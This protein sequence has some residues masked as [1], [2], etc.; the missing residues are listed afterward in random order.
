M[1]SRLGKG[2]SGALAYETCR[3]SRGLCRHAAATA[4]ATASM[5]RA[6]LLLTRHAARGHHHHH[7][8]RHRPLAVAQ[9]VRSDAASP[10]WLAARAGVTWCWAWRGVWSSGGPATATRSCTPRATTVSSFGVRSSRRRLDDGVLKTSICRPQGCV[11]TSCACGLENFLKR[12]I[13]YLHSAD[14]I[15]AISRYSRRH[16]PNVPLSLRVFNRAT[17]IES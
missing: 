8:H 15:Q 14:V 1:S 10:A 13:Y 4:I 17:I 7:L 12:R 6:V 2:S 11:K 16:V 9:V 5:S 3:Q